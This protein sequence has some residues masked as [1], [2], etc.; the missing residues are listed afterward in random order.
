MISVPESQEFGL[1]YRFTW[2]PEG[3]AATINHLDDDHGDLKCEVRIEY[4]DPPAHI[5]RQRLNCSSGRAISELAKTLKASANHIDWSALL[6][7]LAYF[8]IENYRSGNQPETIHVSQEDTI[9]PPSFLVRPFVVER[10]ISMLYA[11]GGKGKSLVS[12]VLMVCARMGIDSNLGITVKKSVKAGLLD[13]E[14]NPASFRYRTTRLLR[15]MDYPDIELEYLRC[16]LPLSEDI[17][18]VGDWIAKRGIDFIVVDS[19][20]MATG[21]SYEMSDPRSATTMAQGIRQLKTAALLIHH[22]AKGNIPGAPTTGFGSVYFENEARTVWELIAEDVVDIDHDT[23]SM[24]VTMRHKKV[25][26]MSFERDLSWQF[27]F[28]DTTISVKRI[29]V[30]DCQQAM[31]GKS[32]ND[33]IM[34]ILREGSMTPSDISGELET[35]EGAVRTALT[36]LKKMK[37]V[38]NIGENSWGRAL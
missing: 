33:R 13:Y 17:E 21:R 30:E 22:T 25:N 7:Q 31:K 28:T 10:D 37:K 6:E 12:Q 36:R 15:G 24:D 5:K 19:V 26:D 1:G 32:L 38:I 29:S 11:R 34:S 9:I 14:S 27:T 20:G 3:I 8:T 2:K 16:H 18:K 4:L 23:K 35:T